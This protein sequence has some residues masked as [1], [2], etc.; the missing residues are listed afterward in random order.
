MEEGSEFKE[1]IGC[2][3]MAFPIAQLVMRL[4]IE[5]KML[6]SQEILMKR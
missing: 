1:K 6:L 5:I 3:V 2:L 4:F